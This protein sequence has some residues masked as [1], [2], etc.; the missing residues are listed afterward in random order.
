M[1]HTLDAGFRE[2]FEKSGSVI[3]LVEPKSGQIVDANPAA[4]AFYGHARKDLV[5]M[6]LSQINLMDWEEIALERKQALSPER[7]FFNFRHRLASGEERDVEVFF[8]PVSGGDT[9]L[10]FSIV[11]DITGFKQAQQELRTSEAIYRA[12]F[13]TTSD[14][15]CISRSSDGMIIDTSQAFLTML[16]YARDEVIG[17]TSIELNMWATPL[18][19]ERFVVGAQGG[20][21]SSNPEFE[22]VRKSGEAFSTRLSVSKIRIDDIAYLLTVVTDISAVKKAEERIRNL[23]FFDALTQLPNRSL[24]LDRIDQAQ[25]ASVRDGSGLAL[26]LIGINNFKTLNDTLGRGAGDSLLKAVAGRLTECVPETGTVARLG[27]DEFGVLIAGLG[28]TPDETAAMARQIAGKICAVVGQPIMLDSR[29]CVVAAC[30][31][32]KV[33]EGESLEEPGTFLHQAEI[34]LHQAKAQGR[35]GIQFY[36]PALQASANARISLEEDFRIAVKEEQFQ[37]LYQPQVDETGLVGAEA[38]IR[39]N[40]PKRGVVPPNDFIPLAEETGLIV[41]LG[42]W[43]LET[44]CRQIVAWERHVGLAGISIAINISA[45]QFRQADFVEEAIRVIDRSGGN[46]RRLKME[47]TETMMVEK[48][49][50]VIE[51]MNRLKSHGLSFSMDDFG[52]GY[53]SLAYLKRLPL[54]QLKI[55]RAFVRDI[56]ADIA[57]GAIAETVVSLGKAMGLTVIAE[58]VETEEQRDFLIRLGCHSFQGYLYSRP[59]PLQEFEAWQRQF[60]KNFVTMPK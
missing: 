28:A 15:L 10:L 14:A 42:V 12:T 56:L 29:E 52:T 40:H 36:S 3:L 8:S 27:S 54:D 22:M 9:R 31:G 4:V 60:S 13:Q 30:I 19:R 35:G 58:G 24:L 49:E 11:H 47:L 7:N 57:S 21:I 38:L 23:A 41:P 39:W 6:R 5:T 43:V 48:F 34:A 18:E 45:Q 50:D 32:I 51:K 55:D 33:F 17:R 2:V 20:T 44:A 16:G 1:N 59:L 37:L 25:I 46:P 53:S 26:L